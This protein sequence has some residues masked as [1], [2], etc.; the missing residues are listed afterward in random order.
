MEDIALK[1]NRDATL[2]F[3]FLFSNADAFYITA[4]YGLLYGWLAS[5]CNNAHQAIELYIK[6]ILRLNYEGES[7][8]D[9]IKLLKKYK[10]REKYFFEI[11]QNQ[12][13]ADFLKE[14]SD[15]YIILRYGK[16]GSSSNSGE[17]IK[18]LDEIAFNLRNI[19]L[20]NIKSPSKKIYL[21]RNTREDF[22]KNNK[23]FSEKDLTNNVFAQMGIPTGDEFPEDFFDAGKTKE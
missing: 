10:S 8:H 1:L 18:I 7:G 11:L 20:T 4:R 5:G 19:Y 3:L 15:A 2:E 12:E 9:L 22:L 13:H 16:T 6:A 17:I 14:L 21:P 23:F